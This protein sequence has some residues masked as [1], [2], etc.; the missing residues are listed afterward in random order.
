VLDDPAQYVLAHER[1]V[2]AALVGRDLTLTLLRPPFPAFGAG[3]LRVLR[4][5]ETETSTEIVAGY[6]R[7]ERHRG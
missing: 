6:E 3:E 7:Y 2:R 5:R 4:I 1:E